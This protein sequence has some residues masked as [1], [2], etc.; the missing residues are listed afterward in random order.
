MAQSSSDSGMELVLDNRRLVVAFV[1][2]VFVCGI[3]F[4]LGFIEGKRQGVAVAERSFRAQSASQAADPGKMKEEPRP[5]PAKALEN[6]VARDS[7]AQLQWYDSVS[8]NE[9]PSATLIP[10]PAAKPP[11]KTEPDAAS[12]PPSP[13]AGAQLNYT[14]QIGAFHLREDAEKR[15]ELL[16]GKGYSYVIEPPAR[17]GDFFLVKVGKYKSRAEAQA[18]KLKLQ[19][20][21]FNTFIKT[22]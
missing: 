21:G 1:L 13:A 8:K 12:P 5:L 7:S 18:I 10:P 17:A 2:L 16:K 14:V 4:I 15:G 11:Q 9:P 3:F 22:F 19:K 20:D 6:P